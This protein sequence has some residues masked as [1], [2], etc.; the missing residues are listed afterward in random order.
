MRRSL[1]ACIAGLAV[2]L[3][4]STGWGQSSV[5]AS[6]NI[7]WAAPVN[8]VN[9][10]PLAGSANAVTSYNVYASMTPLTAVPTTAALATVTAPATTV[11]GSTTATVGS[12]LYVYVT[13]CNIN[14]CSLLS[15]AG[16]KVITAP[17][18]PPG[19]PTN[20]TV[21]VTITPAPQ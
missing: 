20:V 14:G 13:A 19:V 1:I 3:A 12:M 15:V 7:S 8:D 5:N 11:S 2:A 9:G 21:T 16:T 6:A 4:A 18:A 10:N 17:A